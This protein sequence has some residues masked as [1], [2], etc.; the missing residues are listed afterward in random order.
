MKVQYAILS[1]FALGFS[2]FSQRNPNPCREVQ[3][4]SHDKFRNDWASCRSYFWC[5][6]SQAIPTRP[7]DEGFVFLEKDQLC[8]RASSC[9]LCPIEGT[10]A[11]SFL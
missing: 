10:L 4:H 9:S 11:V 1:V 8:I 2:V 5:N 7:C 3:F 6:G